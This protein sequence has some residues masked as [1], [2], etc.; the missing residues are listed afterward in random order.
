MEH[1]AGKDDELQGSNR[2]WQAF[3]VAG[4]LAEVAGMA[5]ILLSA[6]RPNAA[7]RLR[8]R[9]TGR[10]RAMDRLQFQTQ[11]HEDVTALYGRVA[12]R[13]LSAADHAARQAA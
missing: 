6:P 13:E 10:G 4:Q 11:P 3:I 8:K 2:S 12:A 5:P 9:T 1:H 7:R